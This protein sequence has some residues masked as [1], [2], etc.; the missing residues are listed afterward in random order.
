MNRPEKLKSC[1]L[2]T[3]L[4]ELKNLNKQIGKAKMYIKRDDLTGLGLGGNKLRKLDYIV[5]D[6]KDK[7]YTT[8]LT[9]GGTQTNHGRLTAAAAAANGMKCIIC[10]YGKPPEKMSGNLVLDRIMGAEV[11][12]LD[13]TEI[14][15]LYNV[16]PYDEIA[17]KYKSFKQLCVNEIISAREKL[18]EKVYVVPIGGHSHLGTL[19]YC[20]CVKEIMDQLDEMGES[21][22]YVVTGNGSGGT[23]AGLLLGMKYYNAPFK[24]LGVNISKKA[25]EESDK[26]LADVNE[27]AKHFDMGVTV[28]KEDYIYYEDTTGIGYNIPDPE[29]RKVI[30]QL[31]QAE[32]ILVDPCYTGKSFA[33]FLKLIEDEI[34][35]KDSKCIF[36]HTGGTP[37]LWTEEHLE[38]INKELWHDI[39]V[40]NYADYE[41]K[42]N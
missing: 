1:F 37:A 22:D 35:P 32:G 18:G 26:I 41:D 15:K 6:A 14:K 5:K 9:F 17:H 39:N 40:F 27:T 21:V 20:D 24:V 34:I 11:I 28:D 8:L 36:I 38:E 10:C 23:F 12:F 31:A 33:G 19:G 30:Y 4:H 29:T 7:G 25:K 13:T 2:P 3:P 16:R 42:I